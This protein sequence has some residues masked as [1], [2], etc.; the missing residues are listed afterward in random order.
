MD[1]KD[2]ISDEEV[3]VRA[4]AAVRFAVE[5]KKITNTPIT[6]YDRKTG[7]IYTLNSDDS[8][9]VIKSSVGRGR[10]NDRI[11]NDKKA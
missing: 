4:N 9:T 2:Y 1:R 11:N 8:K 5:K 10:Y 7:T 3:V 6:A